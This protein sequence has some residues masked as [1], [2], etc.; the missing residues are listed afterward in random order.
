MKPDVFLS[1]AEPVLAV[2]NVT[3]TIMYWHEVIGFPNKWT[4]GEPVNHGGVSWHGVFIQ[5]T[6]G[7]NLQRIDQANSIF[8]RVKNIEE[9]YDFHRNRN[10]N[11][12]EP[13]ENKPW[14]LAAYTI[15]EINGYYL[16]FAGALI[17][18]RRK[19]AP[20]V[21]HTVEIIHRR[22]TVSEYME[23]VSSTNAGNQL[24][25]INTDRILSAAI[26]AVVAKEMITGQVIA[27]ALLLGDGVSFYYV[28]DVMV[29]PRWQH[30]RVGSLLLKEL[31]LWLDNNAPP[32]AYVALFTPE[33]LAPFY[34]QFDFVPA[35]GMQRTI[36]KKR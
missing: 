34:Q 13:L 22:P 4:W 12:V 29:H 32:D 36:Q 24:N 16:L 2:S 9:L 25:E 1:H 27:S 30:N 6:Q 8:I 28:K 19:S 11:I 3:D 5:F 33:N 14:Q 18:D 23:L 21:P 35:F 10:A 17:S 31:T 20:E 26:F 15:R 7:A